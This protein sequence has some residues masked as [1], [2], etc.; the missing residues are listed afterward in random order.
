MST[1][2]FTNS[3]RQRYSDELKTCGYIISV[4][5][6]A[7]GGISVGGNVNGQGG[8]LGLDIGYINA[9]G[10]NYTK[11]TTKFSGF[12]IGTKK[13]PFPIYLSLWNISEALRPEYWTT[14]A[15]YES[16]GID[17]KKR[18]LE[19]ALADYADYEGVDTLT[20]KPTVCSVVAAHFV[21]LRPQNNNWQQVAKWQVCTASSRGKLSQRVES[22][23][24]NARDWE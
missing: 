14:L 21:L 10:N 1:K 15:T 8:S 12:I 2:G 24:A 19:R 16:L 7:S 20:G 3:W 23:P 6:Q 5:F 17:Q 18:N 13:N 22:W 4:P 11:Y 9:N